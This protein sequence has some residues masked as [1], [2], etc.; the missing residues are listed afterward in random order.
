M[1]DKGNY[2]GTRAVKKL[3]GV[4]GA[5]EGSVTTIPHGLVLS[6][7]IGLSVLVVAP[8]GNYIAPTLVSV[9]EFQYDVFI[10]PTNVQIDLSAAN[11]GSILNGAIIALVTYE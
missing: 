6:K 9:A 4:T 10:T 1:T 5:T 3:T 8:N 2:S 7:I 11:S